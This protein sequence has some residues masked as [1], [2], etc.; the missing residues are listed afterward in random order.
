MDFRLVLNGNL[1]SILPRFRDIRAFVRRKPLYR[2]PA[3]VQTVALLVQRC[4]RLSSSVVCTE[5]ILRLN[6]AS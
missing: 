4:V 5:C 6:D 3:T 1:G 2:P